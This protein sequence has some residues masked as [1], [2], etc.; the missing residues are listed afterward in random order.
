MQE[1]IKKEPE[2]IASE[3]NLQEKRFS[4]KILKENCF[5][6]FGVC[7]STFFGATANIP[8][9]EYSLS[10]IKNKINEWMKKE[11]KE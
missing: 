5:S 9:G 4:L 3:K 2:A 10:E 8:D 7:T 11:V 6:L 1:K